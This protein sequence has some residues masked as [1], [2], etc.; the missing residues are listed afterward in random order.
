M[1]CQAIGTP[2]LI[3]E[4]ATIFFAIAQQPLK[5]RQVGGVEIYQYFINAAFIKN[6]RDNK[7]RLMYKA[8]SA[9]CSIGNGI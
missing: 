3:V 1:P 2:A 7:S 4:W 5:I 6:D 8:L 9:Y